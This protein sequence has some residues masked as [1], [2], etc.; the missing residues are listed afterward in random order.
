MASTGKHALWLG[1]AALVAVALAGCGGQNA[2]PESSTPQTRASAQALS[3]LQPGGAVSKTGKFG[4]FVEAGS[5]VRVAVGKPQPLGT[6]TGD[7]GQPVTLPI[8]IENV[9]E[10]EFWTDQVIVSVVSDAISAPI[11]G[12]QDSGAVPLPP[13]PVLPGQQVTLDLGFEV[14]DLAD[15]I[16]SLD[17]MGQSS[18]TFH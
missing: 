1:C 10:E 6:Y 12:S 16:V 15:V 3:Q 17:F 5:G 4:E 11:V 7:H 9:G 13:T 2:S 14:A 18:I 8:T